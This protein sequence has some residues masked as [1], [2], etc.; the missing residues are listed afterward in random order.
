MNAQLFSC[1]PARPC[2]KRTFLYSNLLLKKVLLHG[3]CSL[4]S[5]YFRARFH[6]DLST[7]LTRN[8]ALLLEELYKR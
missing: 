5:N 2:G 3:V 1:K 7:I 8:T 6:L 4:R